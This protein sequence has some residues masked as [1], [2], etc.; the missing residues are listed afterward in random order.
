MDLNGFKLIK[1]DL[2]GFEF[3]LK[4][5]HIK[6]IAGGTQDAYM[7]Y[8]NKE[9]YFSARGTLSL[10]PGPASQRSSGTALQ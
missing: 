9:I 8:A 6:P 5:I 2:N 7:E 4:P 10:L 3:L 1:I